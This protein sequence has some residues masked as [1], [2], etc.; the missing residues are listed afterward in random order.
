[1][2]LIRK[3]KGSVE[4]DGQLAVAFVGTVS[5]KPWNGSLPGG[6][7]AIKVK[8][9]G[10]IG[11]MFQPPVQVVVKSMTVKLRD[12]KTVKTMQTTRL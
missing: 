2:L 8:Q 12:G 10:R 5:G 3:E 6:A 7:Q 11:G 4:F 1:M 9:Y